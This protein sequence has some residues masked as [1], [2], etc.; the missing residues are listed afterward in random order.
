M[1]SFPVL[2]PASEPQYPVYYCLCGEFVCVI[3]KRLRLLPARP[4]DGSY[5][6]RNVNAPDLGK[7]KRVYRI[8]AKPGKVTAVPRG[9]DYEIQQRLE[10]ARCGL[11]VAYETEIA[12]RKGDFTFILPGAL[13]EIQSVVPKD[14]FGEGD[15][16]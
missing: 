15:Q 9:N 7:E 8:N 10:C 11:W 12:P 6:V 13:T 16:K 2:L 14:A 4:E 3:D 5:V 1:S